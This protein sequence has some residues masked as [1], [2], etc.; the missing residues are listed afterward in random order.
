[1][2]KRLSLEKILGTNALGLL[3]LLMF[4]SKEVKNGN[5]LNVVDNLQ[6]SKDFENFQGHLGF[7]LNFFAKWLGK[8]VVIMKVILRI[9]VELSDVFG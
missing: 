3:A 8:I 1:M 2:P 6:I 9:L 7:S 4:E 5:A